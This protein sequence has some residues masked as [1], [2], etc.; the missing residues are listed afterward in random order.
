V[1]ARIHYTADGISWY[2]KS[3]PTAEQALEE[4]HKHCREQCWA[5]SVD[6]LVLLE[7][8]DHKVREYL[9]TSV[10]DSDSEPYW[11]HYLCQTHSVDIAKQQGFMLEIED[12]V[13]HYHPAGD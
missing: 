3:F 13:G 7:D 4:A 2:A 12:V 10:E 8:E 5:G 9:I 1:T 11:S 6:L